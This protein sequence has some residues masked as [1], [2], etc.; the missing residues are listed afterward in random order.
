[1]SAYLAYDRCFSM[2]YNRWPL[3]TEIHM[4]CYAIVFL[5][6]PL[7]V[8]ILAWYFSPTFWMPF[9]MLVPLAFGLS[10]PISIFLL[11]LTDHPGGSDAIHAIKSGFI[12][13]GFVISAGL[14][15]L[16]VKGGPA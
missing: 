3:P 8:C 10:F 5:V 7:G 4:A 11:E 15:F 2:L 1:M 6:I 12:F 14:P 9:L 16:F 13:F